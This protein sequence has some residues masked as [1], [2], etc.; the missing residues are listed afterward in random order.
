MS[1]LSGNN[2]FE[3]SL[4]GKFPDNSVVDF[5]AELV[6]GRY[7]TAIVFNNDKRLETLVMQ[8]DYSS[9]DEKTIRF[10]PIHTAFALGTV[11]IQLL[12]PDS[13]PVIFYDNFGFGKVGE[14]LE[15]P[16]GSYIIGVDA[17]L[18]GQADVRFNI[19]ELP[20]RYGC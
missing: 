15:I 13:D 9:Q 8:D 14:Y 20:I 10:R 16:V 7:Y 1:V 11:D 17:D 2:S 5:S 18:D 4:K 3:I 12:L 19:P 6:S